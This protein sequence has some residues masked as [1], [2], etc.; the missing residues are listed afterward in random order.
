MFS[1]LAGLQALNSPYT[2]GVIPLHCGSDA[3][4]IWKSARV[5]IP[6][7]FDGKASL[8]ASVITCSLKVMKNI[9]NS[10]P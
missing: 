7:H 8:I 9:F 10:A 2:Q 3:V 1:F 4:P 6:R 5:V